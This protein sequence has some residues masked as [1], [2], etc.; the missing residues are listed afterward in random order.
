MVVFQVVMMQPL[1]EGQS[2]TEDF[3]ASIKWGQVCNQ[4]K[5]IEDKMD[6][7]NIHYIIW[8]SNFRRIGIYN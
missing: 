8:K 7:C 1:Q 4:A 2:G 3:V 5:K 6:F